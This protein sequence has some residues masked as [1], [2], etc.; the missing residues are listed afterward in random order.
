MTLLSTMRSTMM[1][2]Y[3]YQLH[4]LGLTPAQ[5]VIEANKQLVSSGASG[6]LGYPIFTVPNGEQLIGAD[7]HM[8]LTLH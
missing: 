4:G 7:G 3:N 2:F 8:N 6:G 5:A 1:H